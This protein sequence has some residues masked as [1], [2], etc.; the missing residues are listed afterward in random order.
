MSD[1]EEMDFYP[2]RL[3]LEKIKRAQTARRWLGMKEMKRRG[4]EFCLHMIHVGHLYIGYVNAAGFEA[5]NI[6]PNSRIHFCPFASCPFKEL[7]G[8]KKDYIQEYDSKVAKGLDTAIKCLRYIG[9]K[10]RR[11]AKAKEVAA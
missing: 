11:K 1:C 10:E 8:I 7:D 6:K 4:C 2:A 3:D 5:R 9:I